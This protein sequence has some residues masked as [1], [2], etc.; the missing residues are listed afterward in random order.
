M[1]ADSNIQKKKWSKTRIILISITL[2][3]IAA[4]TFFYFNFNKLLSVAL[5]KAFESSL[6]SEVY[7]LKFENLRVNPIEGSISVFEVALQ[8]WEKPLH[9]YSYINSSFILKTEGLILKSVDIM[10]LLKSNKLDLD[11]ISITKPDIDLVVNSNN[12]I[13]FPFKDSSAPSPEGKKKTLDSYLLDEFQLI[14]ATFHM[15]I[16]FFQRPYGIS[17]ALFPSLCVSLWVMLDFM[18]PIQQNSGNSKF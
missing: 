14:D 10:L 13:F 15:I 4:G 8:P 12:P 1:N 11:R 5:K 2:V 9:S 18:S 7:E 17:H 6:V 3:L 16:I